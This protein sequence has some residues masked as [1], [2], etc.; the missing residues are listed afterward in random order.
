M[1]KDYS[2]ESD[3]DLKE[4]LAESTEHVSNVSNILNNL[5]WQIIRVECELELT[6]RGLFAEIR[7]L[8]LG[9]DSQRAVTNRF[10]KIG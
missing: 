3:A 5:Q 6:K 1:D 9:L 7:Q 4:L 10:R 2:K 8:K